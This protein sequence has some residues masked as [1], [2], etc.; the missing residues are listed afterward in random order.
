MAKKSKMFNLDYWALAHLPDGEIGNLYP[1]R[2]GVRVEMR[3]F[4]RHGMKV[5][6]VRVKIAYSLKGV[7]I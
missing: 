6:P 4:K 2:E 1:K 3:H 5:I 7:K